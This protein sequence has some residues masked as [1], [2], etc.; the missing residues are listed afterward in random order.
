MVREYAGSSLPV[1]CGGEVGEP[2]KL[3]SLVREYFEPED[4]DWAMRVAFCESSAQPWHDRNLAVSPALAVGAF[5]ML[6]RYWPARS[7]AAGFAGFSA[8]DMRAN[9]ATAA[10]LF[11]SSGPHHWNPSRSCWSRLQ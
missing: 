9:V 3:E 4:R 7:S 1:V 8:Y 10:H 11:Y 5:Q 6:A 2:E